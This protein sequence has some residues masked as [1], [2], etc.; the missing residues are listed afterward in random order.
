MAT[1]CRLS[2]SLTRPA[3]VSWKIPKIFYPCLCL[4]PPTPDAYLATRDGCDAFLLL[5][6]L[7]E[8]IL[9]SSLFLRVSSKRAVN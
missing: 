4:Q 1:R 6:L 3:F 5:C 2:L 8:L 7:K 9:R